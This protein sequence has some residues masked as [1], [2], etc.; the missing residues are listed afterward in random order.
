MRYLVLIILVVGLFVFQEKVEDFYHH[1]VMGFFSASP[2][3]ETQDNKAVAENF[4]TQWR[5]HQLGG[6]G[7]AGLKILSMDWGRRALTFQ[8][9]DERFSTGDDLMTK[10]L[11]IKDW[12]KSLTAQVCNHIGLRNLLKNGLIYDVFFQ[13][14]DVQHGVHYGHLAVKDRYCWAR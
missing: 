11:A 9:L 13:F 8:V 7:A 12:Q 3:L 14:V 5:Y 1:Q 6:G 2:S 10:K 4:A